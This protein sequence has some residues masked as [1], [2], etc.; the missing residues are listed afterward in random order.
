MVKYNKNL[1][2]HSGSER[3]TTGQQTLIDDYQMTCYSAIMIDDSMSTF[4]RLHNDETA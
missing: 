4:N 2:N 3:I 1:M